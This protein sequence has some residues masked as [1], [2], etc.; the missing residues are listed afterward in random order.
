M[1]EINTFHFYQPPTLYS[2]NTLCINY[3]CVSY[4]WGPWCLVFI[5]MYCP[6]ISPHQTMQI[7]HKYY[8]FWDC[9]RKLILYIGLNFQLLNFWLLFF[10]FLPFYSGWINLTE[11]D[12]ELLRPGG[13]QSCLL[14]WD[15]WFWLA[16]TFL[17]VYVSHVLCLV[18]HVICLRIN[19][20]RSLRPWVSWIMDVTESPQTEL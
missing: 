16:A 13:A 2:M 3:L 14:S 19:E 17:Y 1:I 5:M 7:L 10:T 9:Q 8:T 18:S 12:S 6:S 20:S 11:T 15:L 4:C